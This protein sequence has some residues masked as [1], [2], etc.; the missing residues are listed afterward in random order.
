L[1]QRD[2]DVA[3]VLAQVIALT[4]ER[5]AFEAQRTRELL[6]AVDAVARE[7][8]QDHKGRLL[9]VLKTVATTVSDPNVSARLGELIVSVSSWF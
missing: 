9:G 7:P 4:K 8:T 3:G 6:A 2:A 5:D 1:K